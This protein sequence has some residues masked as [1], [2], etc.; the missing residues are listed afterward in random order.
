M[1]QPR[2]SRHADAVQW[3][4]RCQDGP[5][6]DAEEQALERWLTRDPAH[7]EALAAVEMQ[8]A[9]AG[10]LAHRPA[11]R[12]PLPR[13][14]RRRV[15]PWL[16]AAGVLLAVLVWRG[17]DWWWQARADRVTGAAVET[18]TLSD[19]SRVTLAGHSALRLDYDD[20]TRTVTLLR[21]E[22]LFHPA[23]VT[24]AEPRPFTVRAGGARLTARGTQFWVRRLSAEELRVGVLEHRV[25]ARLADGRERLLASGDSARLSDRAGIRPLTLDPARAAGWARGVLVFDATPLAQ[26]LSRINTFRDR[27]VVLLDRARAEAPVRAV[28][29]LDSLD[30]GVPALADGLGLRTLEVP[31]L[32]L[33]Y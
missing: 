9:L 10:E 15:A 32:T 24:G 11:R 18:L 4:L 1:T 14:A 12:R 20:R 17:P 31:G 2:S 6:S 16:A 8:W 29:H 21:G 5:L 13:P 19:G 25:L 27:P 22:A 26:A 33:L 3:W 30:R 7:G 28:L 23:P